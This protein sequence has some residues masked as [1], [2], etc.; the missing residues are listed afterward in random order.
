MI[1]LRDNLPTRRAPV[2][3]LIIIGANAY[4]YLREFLLGPWGSQ[5]FILYYG[6][7]PCGLT[8]EC[9]IVGRA[10]SPEVTLLTSMFVH[11]GFFHFAG[12]MLYLWI[13][14]NNVEDSMGKIRFAIFYPLCGLGAAFVQI[15][16]SPASRI[17]MV[18]ASGAISGVLGAY[19]LLFPHARVLTLIPLGF[20]TQLVEIPA[21][22]VLGFWI[23]VQL[24]NGLLTFNFSG[25][26]VAWFAH[27]GGFA[28]GMLL[29][30]LF[31]RRTV[32]WGWQ[33][34]RMWYE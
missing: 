31:K 21:V 29:I 7:I 32:P 28:V 25:G 26:G 4:V 16:V 18:G 33:R 9:E 13:F 6:L 20:F 5:R 8:G 1:P 17:P 2:L 14:G 15:F 3:T 27:V 34:R 19:L 24:F 22:I 30:G 10:F 12:N 11:A 23:V